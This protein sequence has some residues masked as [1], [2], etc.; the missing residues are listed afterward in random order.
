MQPSHALIKVY[1]DIEKMKKELN[2]SPQMKK[3][4]IEA[5]M[6]SLP[7]KEAE[8]KNKTPLLLS[9]HWFSAWALAFSQDGAYTYPTFISFLF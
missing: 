9:F 2:F 7:I 3:D 6:T 4:Q 1:I 8:K 5:D